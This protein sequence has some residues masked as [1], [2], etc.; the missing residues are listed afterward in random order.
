M[1]KYINWTYDDVS[2]RSTLSIFMPATQGT[3]FFWLCLP[4]RISPIAAPGQ[5]HR[6]TSTVRRHSSASAV[7]S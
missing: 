4:R 2:S 1:S 3:R 5:L 6:L 7:L